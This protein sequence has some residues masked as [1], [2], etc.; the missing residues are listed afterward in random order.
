MFFLRS[1][2]YKLAYIFISSVSIVCQLSIVC[3]YSKGRNV[4]KS[5]WVYILT[6]SDL[7][8]KWN[9]VS[10]ID[11]WHWPYFSGLIKC[12]CT[13]LCVCVCFGGSRW[14]CDRGR[15]WPLSV[16]ATGSRLRASCAGSLANKY[17]VIPRRSTTGLDREVVVMLLCNL[18]LKCMADRKTLF[19]F[20]IHPFWFPVHNNTCLSPIHSAT[21][22][23]HSAPY[24]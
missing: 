9:G 2:I 24:Y 23:S 14:G 22:M 19:I 15:R 1:K 21:P 10:Q 7:K 4:F 6:K 20:K 12:V 11:L 16:C 3:L 18:P 8:T 17:P 5:R 13:C